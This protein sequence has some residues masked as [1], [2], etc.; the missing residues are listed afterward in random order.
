ME[1]GAALVR[2]ARRN[3]VHFL[4]TGKKL[5]VPPDLRERFA[6]KSGAFVTLSKLSGGTK[7]LRGC[8]GYP[9]PSFPLFRAVQ[10]VSISAAVDDPRFPRVKL[11]EMDRI[12]V[13]VSVLTPPERVK[14]SSPEE[15][16]ERIK[17]GRD[18]LVVSRGARRGLLLPQVPVEAGRNWDVE[19]FLAHTCRKA[20]L[21]PDAWR[22]VEG[23]TVEAFQAIVFE[24]E[25]PGGEVKRKEL[26][27]E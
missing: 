22:D 4:E 27:Y 9:L 14:V 8:I 24:E 11:E 5:D 23:T 18:G 1:D 16:L 6:E 15:Y 7:A 12:C 3:V 26:E 10:D 25:T 19:T 17:V 13:E 20:W 21:P 2:F